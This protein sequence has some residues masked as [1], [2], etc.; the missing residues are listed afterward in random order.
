MASRNGTPVN[1][2]GTPLSGMLKDVLAQQR[3]HGGPLAPAPQPAAPAVELGKNDAAGPGHLDELPGVLPVSRAVVRELQ[4]A[5]SQDLVEQER[6]SEKRLSAEDQLE[7]ARSLVAKRVSAWA[8]EEARTARPL[9]GAQLEAVRQA[10]LDSLFKAGPLQKYLDDPTVENIVVDGDRV[11]VDYFDR[12]TQRV[13]PVAD[14]DES[15]VALINRLAARS[16]HGD[17]V[18]NPATPMVNFRLPDRSRVAATLL[19]TRPTMA[20]RRHRV[21]S[22]SLEDLVEWGTLSPALSAFLQGLVAAKQTMLI[23]GDMGVGKTSLL[24]AL[25]RKVGA[26]ER[27]VT[28]ETDRELFLDEDPDVA[29]HVMAMEERASNGEVG[30]DGRETGRITISDMYPH[31]LRM[32]STR[33]VVGEVRSTEVVPMLDAM[34]SG[35]RGSMCTLHAAYPRLVLPRL[36]Q[37][38]QSAGKDVDST[39]QLVAN[40]VNFVIFIR[41][42][43]QTQIGGR[44]HRYVSDVLQVT[45]GEGGQP[46][47]SRIFAPAGD[48]DP[49][50][51]PTDLPTGEVMQ[52]LADTGF[53]KRWLTEEQ[54]GRWPKPMEWVRR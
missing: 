15:L 49:R 4:D 1:G 19:T 45:P 28:L 2:A 32:L 50:G 5:V 43:D 37:L 54:Y 26:G 9:S 46:A 21:M 52:E 53:D 40:A 27:I 38:C 33:V 16:G 35:G 22:A 7:L 31:T 30:K 24:R 29:A 17:R 47:F 51:V 25:V 6:S 20:I 36:V 39:H 3:P 23:A 14:D 12:P 48:G 34:S 13:D 10:I 18:L 42:T 11:L 41:Q 8:V 44:R